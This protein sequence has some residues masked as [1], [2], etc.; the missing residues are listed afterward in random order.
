MVLVLLS[1][2][3]GVVRALIVKESKGVEIKKSSLHHTPSGREENLMIRPFMS[4]TVAFPTPEIGRVL[5]SL[6]RGLFVGNDESRNAIEDI[7][8]IVRGDSLLAG[9]VPTTSKDK[10]T[11]ACSPTVEDEHDF[12]PVTTTPSHP[13]QTLREELLK[14]TVEGALNDVVGDLRNDVRNLHLELL[15]GF[16]ENQK[17]T[18]RMLDEHT[19]AYQQLREEA[20]ALREENRRLRI[21]LAP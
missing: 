18:Q 20:S 4:K 21:H 14:R 2:L 8:S 6:D 10:E 1:L 9:P 13:K 12:H 17:E 3:L 11:A 19:T 7:S 16:H 15:R 5:S